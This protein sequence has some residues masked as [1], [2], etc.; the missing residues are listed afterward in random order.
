[1]PL[2]IYAFHANL[3]AGNVLGK[4]QTSVGKHIVRWAIVGLGVLLGALGGM[5]QTRSAWMALDSVDGRSITLFDATWGRV[6]RVALGLGAHRV[7][8]VLAGSCRIV[9]TL[10]GK[11]I[12]ATLRGED[13]RPLFDESTQRAIVGDRW[14]TDEMSVSPDGTRVA[15]ILERTTTQRNVTTRT[16]HLAVVDVA[17]GALALYSQT[18]REFSPQWSPDGAWLAYLSYDERVAGADL[19]ATAVPTPSPPPNVTPPPPTLVNEADIWVVSADGTTKYRLTSFATGSATMPRWSPDGKLLSFIYSPSPSNDMFWMIANQANAIPTQ[20]SYEWVQA[21]DATWSPDGTRIIGVARGLKGVNEN[22][23][24]SI[25]LV[26]RADQDATF[27][28]PNAPLF[29]AD[30]PRFSPDGR[31]LAVRTAYAL[32]IVD[33]L[34]AEV[35]VY[36]DPAWAMGNTPAYWAE[37]TCEF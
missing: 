7:W 25:P 4:R 36:D 3:W 22:R 29:S 17:T 10:D 2:Q 27:Y 15:L 8:G 6:E 18:G 34:S 13:V 30:Y 11:P 1:M 21:M 28:L 23:L 37:P 9:A 14:R 24:W 12:T 32:A 33:V 35:R 19:F 31:F 16:Y 20:L 26:G 5:A